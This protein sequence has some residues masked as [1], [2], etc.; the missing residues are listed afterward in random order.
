[1]KKTLG[2]IQGLMRFGKVISVI[3][4]AF[5]IICLI[6]CVLGGVIFITMGDEVVETEEGEKTLIESFFSEETPT[7]EALYY[8][9]AVGIVASIIEIVLS[10]RAK[11]Y[12]KFELKEGTPFTL[13]GAKKLKNFGVLAVV[14]PLV[15][16]V[17]VFV[18]DVLLVLSRADLNLGTVS[19][20]GSI[21]TGIF[22]LV[23][24]LVFK[25]GAELNEVQK[26]ANLEKEQLQKKLNKASER[27]NSYYF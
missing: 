17:A 19:F 21:G 14:L 10:D 13:E 26:K 15:A 6:C 16:G 3:V 24:A 22:A 20:A 4:L 27:R 18:I 12:F 11:K 2:T 25:H 9:L 5:S 1:M 8:L 23:M 7:V